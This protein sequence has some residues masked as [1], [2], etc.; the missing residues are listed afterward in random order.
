MKRV[1]IF[2]LSALFLA[3]FPA[4]VCAQENVELSASEN[5]RYW[6]V[7]LSQPPLADGGSAGA[8][9]SEKQ[10]FR[11]AAQGAGIAYRE[12][13]S[14]N[15]LW[16]G[17]SIEIDP[18]DLTRVARLPGVKAVYP[19]VAMSLP[20]PPDDITPQL[21]TAL[22]MTGADVAQ[23]D[24]GLTGAGVNVGI[25]DTGLDYQHPDLGGCF[26]SGCRVFTGYDF[27]GDAFNSSGTGGALIPVPD[28]D[29]DDCNGHGTHVSG[30]VGANGLVKGVAPGVRYGAYRVFGCT[31]TTSA[32][33]MIAAMERALADGMHI[34]NM[35]IGSAR[36]WPQYPTAAA[37]TR[38]VNM[39]VVVVAS[40]GNDGSIGLYGSSA[41][42]LGQKVISVANFNNTHSNSLYFTISPDN[43]ITPYTNSTN[44]TVAPPASGTY[45]MART[46]TQT[47]TADACSALP[48]GSLSGYV[49]LIRRGTCSFYVKAK[50]AEAAGALAVVLY[51][52]AAGALTPSVAPSPAGS[53][54]V[55]IPFVAISQADGNLIDTRLAAGPV[56]LTWTDQFVS[57]PLAA[58]AAGLIS[59]SSSYGM[60]P[61]LSIKPDIGAP[62]GTILSTYP[63]EAGAYQRLSGTSM[64][65]PHVAGAVAL[66][67]EAKPNTPAQAVRGIL[68]NS[69]VPR[70]WWG[71]PALGFMDNVHRQGAGM[72]N[73]PNAVMA[74]TK[75]E[76]GKLDLG[77]SEFGPVTRTLW[78]ENKGMAEVTYDLWHLP[79]LATGPNTFSVSFFNAPADVSFSSPS[80]TVPAGGSASVDVTIAPN[81]G[82]ADRSL[83]GGYVVFTPPAGGPEYRVPF[84][85]FKG[86][87]QGFPVL[88]P[89][90]NNF[91]WLAR[92]TAG[93]FF[94]RP[95][96]ETYSMVDGDNIPYFLIHFDHQ[97]RRVRMEIFDAM[98]GKAWHRAFETEY[99]PRNSGASS[100]FSF[101]WDG[102]TVNGNKLNMV[103]NGQ[104]VMVL[105][106]EKALSDGTTPSHFE[107]W[108]SPVITIARP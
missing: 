78:I 103:P 28:P 15:N 31:G 36:Q 76:P 66:L 40:A 59:T 61:D 46:G 45:P 10:A 43:R 87:Y 92:L 44:N 9:K 37:S 67:L 4:S 99:F 104:Y 21:F 32:D 2:V 34:I 55:V 38:L 60:S 91:P 24:L 83:Y 14:F 90:A 12:R 39:G 65:S 85:G 69:A 42:A 30:I 13:Y 93:T 51:N 101:S 1:M 77:E 88:V 82:L 73:I 11:A 3:T 64:S 96:G 72:L 29:P 79:A 89:T 74:T 102:F 25:I 56:D 7:E 84:A 57:T 20:E 80:V 6:L 54:P 22:A 35:S 107:T 8:L 106:I 33:I 5:G 52:N 86:D 100:F 26:G 19:N 105:T 94:N 47:S 53:P 49:A 71:N 16:N 70:V 95:S 68:Q 17:L 108:T 63:I 27:V 41:P 81:P 23:N 18:K 58:S 48:A 62:G 97:V 98:S 75:I 50:N